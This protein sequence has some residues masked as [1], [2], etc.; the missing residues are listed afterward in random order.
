MNLL[1]SRISNAST[2]R[3]KGS[4]TDVARGGVLEDENPSKCEK[5]RLSP[6]GGNWQLAEETGLEGWDVQSRAL[7]ISGHSGPQGPCFSLPAAATIGDHFDLQ[8]RI[9]FQLRF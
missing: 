7:L 6:R 9:S 2:P 1:G 4:E 5:Q 3:T 8:D